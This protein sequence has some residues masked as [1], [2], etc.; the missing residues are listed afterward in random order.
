[1]EWIDINHPL[2]PYYAKYINF[3]NVKCILC[4]S[5]DFDIHNNYVRKFA[6]DIYR[7]IK[8]KS[9]NHIQ[10]FPN[11]YDVKHYYDD[12]SQDNEALQISNRDNVQ[13]REMVENQAFRRLS[14]L[15][16]IT[17]LE[18]KNIIDI[19]GGYGDFVK[20]TSQK[21]PNS[22]ITILEPGITRI[23]SS[24][25]SN[26]IKINQLL[27]N[28][29]SNKNKDKYDIITS[30]HVLEH[31]LNPFEFIQNCYQM[32]KS[33]GVL[34]IEVPNQN[35]DIVQLSEYYK[36]NIWYMKAHI[37]YFTIEIIQNILSKLDITNYTFHGFERYDYENY[38]NWIENNYPQKECTYYTGIPKT[39]EEAEWIQRRESTLS[40]DCFYVIIQKNI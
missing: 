18:N 14:I 40:T 6:N 30:F 17:T 28:V 33:N 10:L 37:S 39:T 36:N 9:C 11:N 21:Y 7:I 32:L 23:H 31:V 3:K 26:I 29:F 24:Q 2:L 22:T 8:C 1:M 20:Q 15:E 27:D 25:D 34:Y 38:T 19:G 12:D 13:W 35:N 5:H 16:N 4:Q